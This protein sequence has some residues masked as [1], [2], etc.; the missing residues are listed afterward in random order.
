MRWIL[1]RKKLLPSLLCRSTSIYGDGINAM[2]KCFDWYI[3]T[4][5]VTC[6][7]IE[8]DIL[9]CCVRLF[10][11]HQF[12]TKEFRINTLWIQWRDWFSFYFCVVLKW[13]IL[14]QCSSFLMLLLI[15]CG[16][17]TKSNSIIP[18]VSTISIGQ[19]SFVFISGFLATIFK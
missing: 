13:L 10:I 16:I 12:T 1:E 14:L 5:F 11:P 2:T 4:S 7:N 8:K 17:V 6:E 9:R 15:M 3:K 19:E 18:F